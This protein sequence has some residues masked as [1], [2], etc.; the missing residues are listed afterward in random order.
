MSSDAALELAVEE[1]GADGKSDLVLTSLSTAMSNGDII[2]SLEIPRPILSPEE[3]EGFEWQLTR[4]PN[5]EH[6]AGLLRDQFHVDEDHLKFL[7]DY[8]FGGGLR[9]LR[10]F[11]YQVLKFDLQY[12]TQTSSF[13]S[14]S[15]YKKLA[16]EHPET[17]ASP[18]HAAHGVKHR[19]ASTDSII[20]GF[21]AAGK[22]LREHGLE[23]ANSTVFD[24]GCGQGKVLAI[25][26]AR[27]QNFLQNRFGKAVGVDYFQGVIDIAR[28]N[29]KVPALGIDEKKVN[30]EFQ[31]AADFNKFNGINVVWMYNPFDRKIV[32]EVEANLRTSGGSALVIYN[33]PQHAE[34]FSEWTKEEEHSRGTNKDPDDHTIIFSLR[35]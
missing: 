31:S 34:V 18:D 14:E 6:A 35:I 11:W 25:A 1:K 30:F 17:L 10:Y 19:S 4:A 7:Q 27:G 21:N 26:M 13:I 23:P 24:M 5:A 33:K 8:Q 15:Y 29:M 32:S 3:I 20:S 16:A 9:K 28:K 12:G 2:S 22:I